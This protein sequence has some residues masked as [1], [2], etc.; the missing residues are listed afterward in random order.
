[1]K[2]YKLTVL[3]FALSVLV[4]SCRMVDVETTSNAGPMGRLSV[5]KEDISGTQTTSVFAYFFNSKDGHS[6]FPNEVSI[7]DQILP[8]KQLNDT[9]GFYSLDTINGLAE[10]FRWKVTGSSELDD[11]T[12]LD[13]RGFP[14]LT[15]SFQFPTNVFSKDERIILNLP[16]VS[17]CTN[18]RIALPAPINAKPYA[19]EIPVSQKTYIIEPEDIKYYSDGNKLFVYIFAINKKSVKEKSSTYMLYNETAFHA[20][21]NVQ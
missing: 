7:D 20:F 16:T 1:M 15:Q 17:N 13:T 8:F 11:F 3:L 2:I 19:V 14:A 21:L 5:T 10:T 9:S 6:I 12:Y 4:T 18:F